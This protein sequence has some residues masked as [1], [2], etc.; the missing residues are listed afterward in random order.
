MKIQFCRPRHFRNLILIASATGSLVFSSAL[1]AQP[2]NFAR[3]LPELRAQLDAQLNQPRFSGALWGVK[4]VSLDTRK[5]L[6]ENHAD[7]LMSPASNSKLYAGALALDTFGGDYRFVTPIF[8]TTKP[9]ETGVI[10]GDLIISGR[11]DPS[12]KAKNFPDIFTPFVAALTNAG[13]R[14]IT[15]DLVADTT[16][17]HGPPNGGSWCVEDLSDGE[18]AEISAL[19]LAD[20]LAEIRVAPGTNVSDSCTLSSSPR[21]TGIILVNRTK[22]IAAGGKEHL[23]ISKPLGTKIIYVLGEMPLDAGAEILDAPVPQPA[24]WFG[25]ALKDALAQNGI[26][27]DGHVRCIAWPEVPPW[28]ETN[29]VKIGE[30]KSPPLRELVRDF[31]KPSQ[32]LETD[33]VFDHT[34]EFFRKTNSP[35]WE[36]SE[37]LA[38]AALEKF[39]ARNG[40]PA[41]VHFDEGSGLSRNNLTSADATVALLALMAKGRWAQDYYDALPVAGVDGTLRHRLNSTPA[42]KNVRA[43]TGTLR[44]VNSLSGY[45][46]TAAGEKLVFSLM[47]NRYDPPPGRKRTDELDDIA[48]RLAGINWRE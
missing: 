41:D 38:V 4:I 25:A 2:T 15:G 35:P 8:A 46:T 32:N 27:V 21:D 12:W 19:T 37:E 42:Y 31:M 28:N 18:G 3:S 45:V 10:R 29:L 6:Y 48:V 34:G 33:L 13:V 9:D 43:K 20:N 1:F 39:L 14:Q 5:I 40:I 36:T 23:E 44:W 30:V 17:F 47:L 16:F 22:T 24:A 11:G 26:A 7:R